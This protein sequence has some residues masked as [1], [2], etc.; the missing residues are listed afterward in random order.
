MKT[1]HL[2]FCLVTWVQSLIPKKFHL[3]FFFFNYYFKQSP[4]LTVLSS[5]NS[6]IFSD[7]LQ[8]ALKLLNWKKVFSHPLMPRKLSS[9]RIH[10]NWV[11]DRRW[12]RRTGWQWDY[13]FHMSGLAVLLFNHTRR[14]EAVMHLSEFQL[15]VLTELCVWILPSLK[16]VSAKHPCLHF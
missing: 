14:A 6:Q 16:T 10:Q 2:I 5:S 3:F 12:H 9:S 8:S 15:A 4:Q 11:V 7:P 1:L 13:H